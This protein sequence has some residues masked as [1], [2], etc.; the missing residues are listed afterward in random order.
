MQNCVTQ[1]KSNRTA[2]IVD[3]HGQYCALLHSVTTLSAEVIKHVF[4]MNMTSEI[5]TLPDSWM[6][7]VCVL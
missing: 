4:T 3:R 6:L 5:K 7:H 2:A 1:T